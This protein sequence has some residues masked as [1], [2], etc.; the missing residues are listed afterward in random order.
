M[1]TDS[2]TSVLPLRDVIFLV[3]AQM[4][5]TKATALQQVVPNV[6]KHDGPAAVALPTQEDQINRLECH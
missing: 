1:P 6:R 3:S 4:R 2:K 5:T